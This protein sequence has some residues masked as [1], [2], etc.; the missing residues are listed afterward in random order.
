MPSDVIEA[1]GVLSDEG[2][3]DYMS[4]TI[5]SSS[6]YRGSMF[7]VPPSPTVRNVVEGFARPRAGG[8]ARCR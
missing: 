3:C 1:A 5:G 2:L 7:I 6:T 8:A 4:V